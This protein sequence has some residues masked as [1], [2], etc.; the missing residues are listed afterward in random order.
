ML[1]IMAQRMVNTSGHLELAEREQS[2]GTEG[3]QTLHRWLRV[4]LKES[5]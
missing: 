1:T 4:V 5:P 2:V 3:T